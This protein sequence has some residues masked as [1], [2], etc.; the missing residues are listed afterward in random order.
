MSSE[1]DPKL[2]QPIPNRRAV[3]T[4]DARIVRKIDA[5]I[6]AE[7]LPHSTKSLSP[8]RS[9]SSPQPFDEL[10]SEE[11]SMPWISTDQD[12]PLA[13]A[14]IQ[15]ETLVMKAY[16]TESS[17]YFSSRHLLPAGV[18]VF[19]SDKIRRYVH[20]TEGILYDSHPRL[21][22]LTE[23]ESQTLAEQWKD[24]LTSY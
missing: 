1:V 12:L 9:S 22:L 20:P 10:Q 5:G 15:K 3:S 8:R 24:A 4:A 16:R 13:V 18:V 11:A 7:L 21:Q 6:F 19:F 14:H 17:Y 23:A 2:S